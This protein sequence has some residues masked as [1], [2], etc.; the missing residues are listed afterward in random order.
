MLLSV[1]AHAQ[2]NKSSSWEASLIA[3][4][5]LPQ[6]ITGYHEVIMTSGVRVA[7]GVSA[8]R[9]SVFFLTGN[10]SGAEFMALG[11]DFRNRITLEGMDDLELNWTIGMQVVQYRRPPRS[12]TKYPEARGNGFHLGIGVAYPFTNSLAFIND[13]MWCVGPGRILMVNLGLRWTFGESSDSKP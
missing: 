7:K 5:M 12:G 8:F 9:P 1:C 6:N 2:T 10:E 4:P 11:G 3:G 13:Y